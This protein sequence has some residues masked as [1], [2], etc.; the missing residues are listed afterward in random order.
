VFEG[1]S[2]AVAIREL[3]RGRKRRSVWRALRTSKDPSVFTVVGE[4]TAALAGIV[5][6]FLGVLLATITGN[7]TFDALGSLAVGAILC[8]VAAFL[9]GECR[10]LLVGESGGR[11][12]IAGV[13]RIVEADPSTCRVGDPLTM[14][15]GPRDVLLNLV[16]EFRSDLDMIELRRAIRRIENRVREAHPEVT[17]IFIEASSLGDPERASSADPGSHPGETAPQAG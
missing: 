8:V 2:L 14:H 13:R 16:V 3:R 5:A 17:R 4:D 1:T 15:L 6:A 11:E 7:P 12:L 10:G 9:A